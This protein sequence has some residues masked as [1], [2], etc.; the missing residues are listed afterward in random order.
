MLHLD[1]V[2]GWTPNQKSPFKVVAT[3]LVSKCIDH[4]LFLFFSRIKIGIDQLQHESV[5]P[6]KIKRSNL[7][8]E[9]SLIL[10]VH[11][12]VWQKRRQNHSEVKCALRTFATP[13]SSNQPRKFMMRWNF[14][15]TLQNMFY[16]VII[17]DGSSEHGAHIWSKW[18]VSIGWRHLFISKES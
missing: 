13:F 11:F 12:V 8:G 3:S 7:W 14:S 17:I 6:Q 4:F 2:Q 9:T 5:T 18:D 16:G 15:G 1:L 10:G